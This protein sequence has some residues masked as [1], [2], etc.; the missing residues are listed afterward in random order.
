M[1]VVQPNLRNCLVWRSMYLPSSFLMLAAGCV[2]LDGI[3]VALAT[4]RG[5]VSGVM[6]A[7]FCV[8]MLRSGQ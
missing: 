3:N 5:T 6:G 7:M 8:C 2:T 4:G 1:K